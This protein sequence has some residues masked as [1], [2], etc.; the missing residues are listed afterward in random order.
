MK[1]NLRNLKR[2]RLFRAEL[3]NDKPASIVR[4]PED[5]KREIYLNWDSAFDDNGT[6]RRC[7]VC[8]CREL[9][10]RKDFPQV[11]GFVIVIV[12]ALVSMFMMGLDQIIPAMAVLGIVV[13]IDLAVF[14]FTGKCLV[15]YRCRSEF[16]D[17]PI[18]DDHPK[19]DLPTGEKYGPV[20]QGETA[21]RE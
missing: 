18:G 10:V 13:V 21:N 7:P 12:A 20:G 2:E 8:G 11:T 5:P 15:C 6:L 4:D 3:E 19:W 16:R 17:T 1:I 9:F 14:F